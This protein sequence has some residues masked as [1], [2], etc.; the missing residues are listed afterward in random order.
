MTTTLKTPNMK[1]IIIFFIA[2]VTLLSFLNSCGPSEEEI[3]RR[4]QARQDSLER[5][6]QQRLQQQRLDS[7]AAARQ[8]SIDAARKQEEQR[9]Q[10][11]LNESGSYALQV[12]AWRSEEKAQSQLST[13]RERGFENA[14]VV[15]VGNEDTGNIWYR[16]RL[17]RAESK[18]AAQQVGQNLKQEYETDFWVSFVG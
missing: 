12:G 15:Q 11:S 13:W 5:V 8:D 14:Y 6:R 9:R 10:L 17:G 3:Q 2:S 16:I 7:I 18:E 1:H 4:E